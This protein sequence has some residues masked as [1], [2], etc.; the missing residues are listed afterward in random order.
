MHFTKEMGLVAKFWRR[1]IQVSKVVTKSS[2]P[3]K[4]KCLVQ[5][6]QRHTSYQCLMMLEDIFGIVNIDRCA[7]VK[8][9]ETGQEIGT[10]S[11]CTVLLKFLRLSNG[12][13]LIAEVNQAK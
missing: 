10:Y 4:I 9:E 5:V 7:V 13:Q 3:R 6:S 11:L 1:H 2:S 8:N 12:N